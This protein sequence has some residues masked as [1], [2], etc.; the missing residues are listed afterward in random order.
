VTTNITLT[1]NEAAA[2]TDA[3]LARAAEAHEDYDPEGSEALA[4]LA[5]RIDPSLRV[6]PD[7]YYVG[8]DD[9]TNVVYVDGVQGAEVR[10]ARHG[11]AGRS[12]LQIFNETFR[13][14][15]IADA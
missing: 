7:R 8:R 15:E 13:K 5:L 9:R 4:R 2:I 12:S 1:P 10:Y 6:E 11:Q 14:V 3:L